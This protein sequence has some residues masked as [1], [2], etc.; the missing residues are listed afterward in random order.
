[1]KYSSEVYDDKV[2]AVS[3]E[4]PIGLTIAEKFFGL[5]TIIIGAIIIYFTYTNPPSSGGQVAGY[6]FVFLIAGLA[7]VA[8]GIFLLL[9]KTESE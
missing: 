5:L 8:F 7:L 3:K 1:M 2:I 6:S 9:A 4:A